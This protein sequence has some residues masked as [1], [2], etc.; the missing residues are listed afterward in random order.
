MPRRP[1]KPSRQTEARAEITIE[2]VGAHGDGTG[3]WRGERVFVPFTLPGETVAVRLG[4][5]TRDGLRGAVEAVRAPSPDRIAPPCPHFGRCGGCSLQHWRAGACAD[6]KRG[7][8][9]AA[10]AQRGLG[11]VVVEP[12]VAIPPGTRRRATFAFKGG[13][14]GF[15]ARSSGRIEPLRECPLLVPAIVALMAPLRA[16]LPAIPGAGDVYVAA[17]ETGLDVWIDVAA[18]PPLAALERLAAFAGSH[19]LARIGWR[20]DGAATPVAQRRA[21]ILT[22]AGTPVALPPRAF[23]QPSAEGEAALGARVV[24]AMD[25][26]LPALD[27]FCGIGTFALRLAALGAVH[28]VDGDAGPIAALVATRRVTAET[29]D[30]L[31]R[32]VLANETRGCRGVVFDPPRAG[33]REQAEALAESDVATVVA[34]SCNPA[35]FAR[36]ARALVDGGYA[37]G[38]VTPVDQFPWSDH[39]EL[40]ARFTRR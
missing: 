33:A 39:V 5:R 24:A 32:P 27:L 23:L 21:P 8:V 30:L 7:R 40:V 34:V 3:A 11:D 29:R 20:A 25:G 19:D 31:R 1:K 26:A 4:T 22:I 35:T 13:A 16:L 6:W 9:V 36:D 28:A 2:A 15:N 18:P 17:T 38:T 10:L 37:L 14:F 12:T